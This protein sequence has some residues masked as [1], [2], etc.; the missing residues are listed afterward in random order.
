MAK[1]FPHPPTTA[2]LISRGIIFVL[3][4]LIATG[5]A[6]AEVNGTLYGTVYTTS[7]TGLEGVE[8][9]ITN[10]RNNQARTRTTNDKGLFT[11][12]GVASGDYE[13]TAKKN[14]F[15]N[16]V[17][18]RIRIHATEKKGFKLPD[19][20]LEPPSIRGNV[21][22]SSDNGLAGAEVIVSALRSN[23]RSVA[24]TDEAGNYQLTDLPPGSYLV[25]VHWNDHLNRNQESL[26]ITL[27]RTDVLVTPIR[28]TDVVYSSPN[29][30]TKSQNA[31]QKAKG[32]DAGAVTHL[33]DATRINSFDERELHSL[34][35][36][37]ATA[38]R[39]FD[40]LALLVPGVAPPPYTPGARGPGVGFGIGTPGQFSVN[41]MRAR[42]NNFSVDGSDNNDPDVGV[43]RQGFIALVPQSID[44]IK[45]F[46]ISTLL[47]D[48]EL[49][50][51]FGSQVNAV[52]DYGGNE[53]HGKVYAFLT[54]SSLNARNFF[55]TSLAGEDSFTRTQLGFTL[56]GPI[57]RNRTHFFSSYE[58]QQVNASTEQHFATPALN[59]R[60]FLDGR[61]FQ[62]SPRANV[63]TPLPWRDATPIGRLVLSQY[64]LPNNPV[65]PYGANTLS[66]VLPASGRGDVFSLSLSHQ[67]AENYLLGARYNFTQDQ[68]I[69]PS[70]NRAINST[71]TSGTRSQDLSL[72]LDSPLGA[73]FF[74]QARF[75][76]GRT[77]LGFLPYPGNPLIFQSSAIVQIPDGRGFFTQSDTGSIGELVIEPYS[78]VGIGAYDFPQSRV[79]NTFQFADS[80]SFVSGSHSIKSG[81]NIRRY[82][83][84]SRSDRLY[85]P[86]IGFTG[87]MLIFE[88][89]VNGI[90]I[91]ER[92]ELSTGV[93]QASLGQ[94]SSVFQTLTRGTPNSTIG[95]R[96]TEYH[97]FVNDT[98]RIRRGLSIDIGVRYEYNSVPTENNNRIEDAIR[99]ENL[100][101][102]GSIFD[103]PLSTLR[104]NQAVDAYR[105]ILDG[106]T[107]IYEADRNN[108]GP[109]AGFAWALDSE[110]QTVLRAGY[111][112]YF[113]SILGAVVS[114]SR[115]VFPN[116]IPINTDSDFFP[117]LNVFD[118][119]RLERN[120]L[121]AINPQ[122][123]F[124]NIPFILPGPCNDFGSCNQV[125]G[126][127]EDF[128]A[129][130]GNIFSRNLATAGLAFTLPEKRLRTPYAQQ[131]QLTLERELF[132]NLLISASYVGTKGTKLTRLTTPNLGP[133]AMPRI[134][135]LTEN[136]PNSPL[137]LVTSG[138]VNIQGI[139]CITPEG[140]CGTGILRRPN[141]SLGPYQIFENSA[142]S[143]YHALQVEA[144]KRYSRGYQFTAA[145]T[146]SHAIDDVSD[147]FPVAGAPVLAQN[148]FNLRAERAS[149]NFDIRHNFA[150]SLVWDVPLHRHSKGIGGF[151]LRNWTIS[152]IFRAHSG[153]PFTLGVPF[154]A[155]ADGN[156]SDRPSNI[157]GL[158]FS[159]G[160]GP[161]RVS[162]A[163]GRQVADFLPGNFV[164]GNQFSFISEL[165]FRSGQVGRNTVRGD[166]F[167]NLDMSLIK[168]FLFAESRSLTLRTDLFNLLN[169]SN[170]GLPIRI[171][172]A[173]GFGSAVDTVTPARMIQ[174]SL[175]FDF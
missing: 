137:P 70:V 25:R 144:R 100:P 149:A 91:I 13:V 168:R 157:D 139:R 143:N 102:P 63:G 84:N 16:T 98:W 111:G 45:D 134:L 169:R 90:P 9:T 2:L 4:V 15:K 160:H 30:Q 18:E 172:G 33:I 108:F 107:R 161:Q 26:L 36:G 129:V 32:E 37:A 92:G 20:T 54:D 131:W 58:H 130:I 76:F 19:I 56:G 77:K 94:P 5:I 59:E 80:I 72:I 142:N 40:E 69:L 47:W 154:D 66:R 96:F 88:T 164:R 3:T 61:E 162:L 28:L 146:W 140:I 163:P 167:V 14:G 153:Q 123:G 34:P 117:F 99:L 39:S 55:D 75:S 78:P 115:N 118:L 121:G 109:H 8:V 95:L 53:F 62:T 116:E 132:S 11:F 151:L 124:F 86:R 128:V 65:G 106:R 103:N 74:N 97:G 110:G 67:P 29:T 112:V 127:P 159:N 1:H 57:V 93:Q 38:M 136:T 89:S 113:D 125:G 51:N 104:F 23:L 10:K 173:P 114:Q 152:S 7:R 24:M 60:T 170:F 68:R 145:Y 150:T 50:R 138:S 43:R 85:R 105:N 141:R 158:V 148:S 175:K 155:N 48:A 126:A 135:V 101:Q 156:L 46:S 122:G 120:G 42:S 64:P 81:V 44:A 21:V 27:D 166:N 49:G 17:F 31:N 41:G 87:Q 73:N 71:L 83:L 133:N 165:V 174:F 12:Y 79:S 119:N 171:I 22:D 6:S 82:Q 35:V 147:L 52:S